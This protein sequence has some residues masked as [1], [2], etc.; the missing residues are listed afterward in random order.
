[1]S[2]KLN[3]NEFLAEL[4]S[5]L[6]TLNS[7]EKI[8]IKNL[9]NSDND[10]NFYKNTCDELIIKF[11]NLSE[12]LN[13]DY[14]EL[15]E[16]KLFDEIL[17]LFDNTE[18]I[19]NDINSLNFAIRRISLGINGF[20]EHEK[21]KLLNKQKITNELKLKKKEE[22]EE[23]EKEEEEKESEK[24]KEKENLLN[25]NKKAIAETTSAFITLMDAIKLNYNSKDTLHPLFTDV[26]TKCPS[27]FAN[28]NKLV[29]W[30]IRLNKMDISE[31]LDDDELK[32]MLWDVDSA[33]N[34]YF[35]AL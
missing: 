11:G 10:K 23:K 24:K 25:N 2:L 32:E 13:L 1:M 9:L 30:L 29:N 31:T 19:K 22:E 26:L 7:I 21:I 6:Y 15:N 12:F 28:R 35:D 5:I 33:Y 27:D 16:K 34:S 17:K 20:E 18:F 4:Y 3:D 8:F 14:L